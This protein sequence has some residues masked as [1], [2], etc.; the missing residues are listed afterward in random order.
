M[1]AAGTAVIIISV[2]AILAVVVI[3][4]WGILAIVIV[5]IVVGRIQPIVIPTGRGICR[6]R[7]DLD[8]GDGPVGPPR[9]ADRL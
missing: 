8:D 9:V 5:G 3:R 2:G 1:T 4:V 7:T 6:S